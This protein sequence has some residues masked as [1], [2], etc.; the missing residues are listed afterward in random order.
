MSTIEPLLQVYLRLLPVLKNRSSL[1]H[2]SPS[3]PTVAH[4]ARPPSVHG[5]R[6]HS[7]PHLAS[8]TRSVTLPGEQPFVP[9]PIPPRVEKCTT[10]HL[11]SASDLD[12]ITRNTEDI[13]DFH[14]RLVYRLRQVVSPFGIFMAP[15][16]SPPENSEQSHRNSPI[17]VHRA[18]N[19]V[20]SVFIDHVRHLS[21]RAFLF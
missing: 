14:E 15:R 10:R 19:A 3:H 9:P 13:L 11:F 18:I 6:T 16:E 20:S 17:D 7:H 5:L 8:G 1:P 12:A 21:S 4:S 2:Q